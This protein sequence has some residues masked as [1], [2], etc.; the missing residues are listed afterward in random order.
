MTSSATVEVVKVQPAPLQ[1][2]ASGELLR[3]VAALLK[4]P[5]N[6]LDLP[7]RLMRLYLESRWPSRRA[8]ICAWLF[9]LAAINA[10]VAL[11]DPFISTA[12]EIWIFLAGNLGVSL[13]LVAGA[14]ALKTQETCGRE[15]FVVIFGCAALVLVAGLGGLLVDVDFM[16]HALMQA[17]FAGCAAIVV[18]R[19]SWTDILILAA[20]LVVL[21]VGLMIA[22]P[23]IPLAERGQTIA[24]YGSA[25]I[26][27]TWMRKVQNRFL[28]R[29]FLEGLQEKLQAEEMKDANGL[30]AAMARTDPLTLLPNRRHFEEVRASLH[31]DLGRGPMALFM[32]DIDFFKR[33]NDDRGHAAGDECLRAVA[34]AIR[35]QLRDSRDFVARFGGEEFVVVLNNVVESEALAVAERVRFAVE[36]LRSPHRMSPFGVVTVS[37]GVAPSPPTERFSML[38]E[39]DQALYD[40]KEAG[41]NCVRVAC[42]ARQARVA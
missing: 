12:P 38:A 36:N 41:R 35:R 20:V 34:D 15:G 39:A 9:G 30:L 31:A 18:A 13:Y 28:Y 26:A 21:L 27:L 23:E 37:I 5:G 25:I 33:L 4:T 22:A 14:M 32:I 8:L 24:L 42:S 17:M 3:L 1:G 2:A 29:V 6:E 7:P 19:I 16:R 11:F 40:A 10:L